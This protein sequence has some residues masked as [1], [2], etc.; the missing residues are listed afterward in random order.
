MTD[1]VF[2]QSI[3][4]LSRTVQGEPSDHRKINAPTE[5]IERMTRGVA[6]PQQA[7]SVPRGGGGGGTILAGRFRLK[8]EAG[9][10][11]DHLVCRTWDGETEGEEDVFIAKAWLLR[12]TPFHSNSP[13]DLSGPVRGEV[14]Y[15]YDAEDS[16]KRTAYDIND[17]PETPEEE[18]NKR[19]EFVS[20][21][22]LVGDEL[23]GL[24]ATTG[25]EVPGF[26]D[27]GLPIVIP[28]KLLDV[29]NRNW[30]VF[31]EHL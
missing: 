14:R 18:L 17:P 8:E 3:P 2:S 7:T 4:V 20:P 6:P 28:V 30:T 13:D 29:S 22:Y 27:E 31:F 11:D 25:I 12:K 23:N 10:T 21:Q 15:V 16:T 1:N 26:D 24:P 19:L 5:A 9:L